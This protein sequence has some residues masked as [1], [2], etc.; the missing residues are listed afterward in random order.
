MMAASLMHGVPLSMLLRDIVAVSSVAD[1]HIEHLSL[2]SREVRPASCFIAL[3]GHQ[4]DG[5]RYA[6]QAIARGAIAV[7]AE[8]P[9]S[10][11]RLD[12]PVL[13]SPH[14]RQHLGVLANRFF[15]SPSAA[16]KLCAVT[17]TNGKTTVAHL[18]AQAVAL[19]GEASGY[20]GTLGAGALG[21]LV[22]LTNTTPDI[23]T[24]N[25]WLASCRARNCAAVALEASS[26]ALAQGRLDGLMISAAAF[27]NLGHDHLDYHLDI[28]N[29]GAAKR[30]LFAQPGLGAAVVNLDDNFGAELVP[31][32]PSNL[33]VWTCS[34]RTASAR[35][36][37]DDIVAMPTGMQFTL[38][39]DGWRQHIASRLVGRFN[40]DNALVVCGLLLAVGYDRDAIV[41]ALPALRGVPGRAEE[42]GQTAAGARVFVDYAHSPDSLAAILTT[43]RDL[44]P[45][46]IV[47]VF[48]CGG[49]RDRSKRPMMGAIAERHAQHVV[50]TS[51]NPRKEIAADIAAEICAGMRTPSAA[52][53][54]LDRGLAIRTAL[55]EA[56][57]GDFV[58][59]AG[60]GHERTQESGGQITPFSDHDEIARVLRGYQS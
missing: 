52:T 21:Q 9:L 10:D 57:E 53:I 35:L 40:V 46:R 5:S 44:A 45:R 36:R 50:I 22:P 59:I 43:L 34:S 1:R 11:L 13:H 42:C 19:M 17:G 60:K 54:I 27:T 14:I 12:V 3:A 37:A 16:L 32:L 25:R 2:D 29:Y 28:E 39:I 31:S 38:E 6:A 23:I 41:A 18:L 58:L 15:D 20:I 7:V 33:N 56:G 48:G 26:H 51:D 49:N 4:D 24:I 47:V 8:R 30:R 55:A